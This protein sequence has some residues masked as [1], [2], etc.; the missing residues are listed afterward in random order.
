MLYHEDLGKMR[1]RQLLPPSSGGMLL[2]RPRNRSLWKSLIVVLLLLTLV[3]MAIDIRLRFQAATAPVMEDVERKKAAPTVFPL[4]YI[5]INPGSA[6]SND[7]V[8]IT[9]DPLRSVVTVELENTRC[10][11]PVLR[12]R[13][14]GPALAMM[15]WN[16]TNPERPHTVP[17]TASRLEGYYHAPVV[18]TYFLEIL[19]IQCSDFK[20]SDD[21]KNVC[22]E[23]PLHNRITEPGVTIRVN[24]T[25]PISV[26]YWAAK[27]KGEERP[28]Y[29]R[30]QPQNCRTRSSDFHSDRCKLPTSL[31]GFDDYEFRWQNN[32][33]FQA[34]DML[35]RNKNKTICFVGDSHSRVLVSYTK[36]Y[37]RNRTTASYQL[38]VH[39]AKEAMPP[40]LEE[41]VA[42]LNCTSVVLGIGAYSTG[43]PG[44][45][46]QLFPKYKRK[47]SK[48]IADMA[49]MTNA[50]VQSIHYHALSDI[51]T[52][53]LPK[54]WQPPRVIDMHNKI[55]R[56]VCDEHGVPFIYDG[57]HLGQCA[58][59]LE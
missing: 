22:L 11:F 32:N 16:N 18:G 42:N 19:V 49:N 48:V 10:P 9:H 38:S 55:L 15:E 53:C 25:Q 41:G 4:E 40:R 56:E 47:M 23:D 33:S 30:F 36:E 52:T 35:L 26:G 7:I 39:F 3:G 5:A 1:E 29:T 20:Y 51:L 24:H 37:A 44:G 27:K 31:S 34:K 28:L 8:S 13:L 6:L 57:S 14:S 46:P 43:L 58:L 59:G 12:G 21:F 50:F 17:F 54:D 45:S 2:D